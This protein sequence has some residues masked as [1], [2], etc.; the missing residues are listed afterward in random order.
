MKL[1]NLMLTKQKF[2]KMLVQVV[3]EKQMS[4]LDA[5][6]H[7]CEESGLDPQDVKK[8]LSPAIRTKIEAEA[9]K[10]NLMVNKNRSMEL[11]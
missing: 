10:L 3:K 8:Y 2:G 7:L 1:N 6:L 11:E 9:T 4:Y 5:V